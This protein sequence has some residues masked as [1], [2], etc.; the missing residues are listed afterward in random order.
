[1]SKTNLAYDLSAFEQSTAK[2]AQPKIRKV[3]GKRRVLSVLTPRTAC[4]FLFVMALASL[5]IYNRVHLNEL[6]REINERGGQLA[7]LESESVRY[8]SMI[9]STAS[10]RVIAEQA[11][12]MGMVRL[13]HSRTVHVYLGDGEQITLFAQPERGGAL[14]GLAAAISSIVGSVEYIPGE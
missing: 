6:T 13:D 5:M 11:E 7:I 14:E 4:V 3:E 1:M 9:E 8:A 10:L 12:Q 2:S